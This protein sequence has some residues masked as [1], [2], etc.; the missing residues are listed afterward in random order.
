LPA[1][2]RAILPCDLLRAFHTRTD[3]PVLLNTSF[4]VV[5]KPIVHS[6]EEA[7]GLFCTTAMDALVV[8]DY[9]IEK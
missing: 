4:N 2:S 3:V 1:F 7:L 5:G 8:E 6:L 9:V